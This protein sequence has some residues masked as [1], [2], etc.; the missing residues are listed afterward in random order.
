MKVLTVDLRVNAV[1]LRTYAV[2][3]RVYAVG[4][5]VYAV[6]LRTYAVDLPLQCI[7]FSPETLYLLLLLT[8]FGKYGDDFLVVF[9]AW[10]GIC[11]AF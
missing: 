3:L 4:L 2:D 1:G 10:A 9:K 8:I 6:G 11:L 5:R 7:Q